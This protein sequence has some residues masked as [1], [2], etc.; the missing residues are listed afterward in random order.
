MAI[1]LFGFKLSVGSS[2]KG[3]TA[4]RRRS[5]LSHLGSFSREREKREG[6]RK[7]GGK[8]EGKRGKG[9]EKEERIKER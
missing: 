6:K 9:R 2:V 8:K 1:L 3:K 5:S 7:N 4:S